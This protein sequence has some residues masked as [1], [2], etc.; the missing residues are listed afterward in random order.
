M[1]RRVAIFIGVLALM[2]VG[3][4]A[5]PAPPGRDRLPCFDADLRAGDWVLYCVLGR[6][7]VREGG[8]EVVRDA[9]AAVEADFGPSPLTWL[10][11][12]GPLDSPL[13]PHRSHQDGRQIDL[14]LYYQNADGEPIRPPVFS[15]YFAYEPPRER[16]RRPCGDQARPIDLGDPPAHRRWRWDRAR[17]QALVIALIDDDRVRRIFIEPH[18]ADRMG[19]ASHRKVRFAGCSAARHDDHIHI[20]LH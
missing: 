5:L 1:I 17:T 13:W 18:L 7:Y 19:L 10:D 15:G 9:H 16:E 12:A 14:S 11:A 8:V 3:L 20:D 6:N 4:A 2:M